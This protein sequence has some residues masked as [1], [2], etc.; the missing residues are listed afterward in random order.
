MKKNIFNSLQLFAISILLCCCNSGTNEVEQPDY[1]RQFLGTWNI[2]MSGTWTD[3]K[4]V[5]AQEYE[6]VLR[7]DPNATNEKKMNVSGLYA[8]GETEVYLD[9]TGDGKPYCVFPHTSNSTY[10]NGYLITMITIHEP[11]K[12]VD[13]KLKWKNYDT[14]KSSNGNSFKGTFECVGVKVK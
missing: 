7:I 14:L 4:E 12:I 6:W 5:V 8:Q 9:K 2:T 3:E 13:G 11:A 1:R 10:K